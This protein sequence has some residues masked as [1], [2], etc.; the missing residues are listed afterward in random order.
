MQVAATVAATGGLTSCGGTRS[1]WRFLTPEE[2]STLTPICERIVPADQ[3]P[4]AAWAGV[5]NYIDRQLVGPFK[6]FQKTYRKG[7]AG[8]GETSLAV[9]GKKFVEL[10]SER[11]TRVLTTLEK[12]QAPGEVWKQISSKQFFALLVGHTMQGFYGDPRHGGNREAV[13]WKMLGVPYPPVRGRLHYDLS[14][15]Q[16]SKQ[17]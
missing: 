17:G 2:A 10:P 11:Q 5:V 7:I 4:G 8:V 15:P 6:R 1:P 9:F 3:D 13:S 14:K 12:D 16:A